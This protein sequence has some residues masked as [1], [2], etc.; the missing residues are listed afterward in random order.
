MPARLAR[1]LL[2][3]VF[4]LALVACG[5]DDDGDATTTTAPSPSDPGVTEP[6]P[7]PPREPLD[8]QTP[9]T[10]TNGIRADADGTLWIA[11]LAGGQIVGV[12]PD[13]GAIVARLGADA[14]VTTPDDLAFDAEGRLW[15]TEF[16]QGRIGRIDAPTA[17]DAT[18][19]FVAE[20]GTGANPIAVADDGRVFVGLTLQG[21]G[22]YEL[23][24][25]DAAEPRLVDPDPGL[26]NGFDVGPDGRIYAPVSDR[27]QVIAIDPGTGEVEVVAEGVDVPVSVRWTPDGTI[28]A[29][30]G[31]PAVVSE[32]DPATGEV[33][34]YAEAA[35]D[36]GDNMAFD[37]DGVLWVTSFNAA[38]VSRLDPDGAV[39]T[40]TVG[41]P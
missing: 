1:P 41:T 30:S 26:I 31:A 34:V 7:A 16:P 4:A 12:D 29:L 17:S 15:W 14:G 36:L 39:T 3:A 10:G 20:V 8:D 9:P 11:D 2:A 37:P 19:E 5:G 21:T 35:S 18:S 13:S 23:D 25:T 24:P 33:T 22:L 27:A 28:V 38:T 40:I 32:V 6:A